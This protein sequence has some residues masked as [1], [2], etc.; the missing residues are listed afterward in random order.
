MF[1]VEVTITYVVSIAC[2]V[3]AVVVVVVYDAHCAAV[4]HVC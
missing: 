1:D 4:L 3:V 2:Y